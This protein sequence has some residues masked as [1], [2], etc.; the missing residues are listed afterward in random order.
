MDGMS[1]KYKQWFD[2][3]KDYCQ[4]DFTDTCPEMEIEGV[5]RIWQR[6]ACHLG[7]CYTSVISGGEFKA[8]LFCVTLNPIW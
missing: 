5:L 8:L 3:H 2:G 4:K 6:S 7:L 1:V